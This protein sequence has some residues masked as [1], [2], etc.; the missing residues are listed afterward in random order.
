M[1]KISKRRRH[2]QQQQEGFSRVTAIEKANAIDL[3]GKTPNQTR[4]IDSIHSNDQTIVLGPAGTGKTY[5]SA[6]AATVMLLRGEI[7][8]MILCRPAVEAEGES[9]GALPGN[10]RQKM[11]PWTYPILE[12]MQRHVGKSRVDRMIASGVI[13]VVPFGFMRG[14]TFDR[15]FVLLDEAQNTTPKQ[16]KLF[17]TRIGEEA[18]VVINGDIS[19]SDIKVES[20]LSVAMTLAKRCS[21]PIGL[22]EFE[23]E[24]IVRSAIARQWVEAFDAHCI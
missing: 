13:E 10:I 16:M 6:T 4:L 5:I 1:K 24:D 11:A 23:N 21:I 20:G 9:Y 22:V 7:D 12:V 2:P 3:A 19:Q 15:A 8:K 17:L 18:R 14:L